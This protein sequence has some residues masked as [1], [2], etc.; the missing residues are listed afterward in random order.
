MQTDKLTIHSHKERIQKGQEAVDTARHKVMQHTWYPKYH[1]SPPA[2][3][4]NDPNGF[5]FYKGEYHLFYQHYPYL[6]KWGPM[7]WGHVKSKD[8]VF[9]ENLPIALAPGENYDLD[10][11]FSGSA[12]E[13]DGKLYLMY[14]GHVLTGPNSDDDLKQ[15]QALA[16]SEDGI[17]FE[18]ID[19]NPVIEHLPKG[20]FHPGH[21][22]DPKVWKRGDIYYVIIGAKTKDSIGQVIL[23]KSS[24]LIHWEFVSVVAKA[25]DNE[26][27]MWECPDLI[28]LGDKDILI[29]SPQGIKAEGIYY[30]NHHQSGYL[31]GDFNY[32]S[33]ILTHG[34]FRLLD[35]GFDFY[36]PQTIIDDKGRRILIAWMTMWEDEM[37]TKEFGWAGAMTLPRVLEL[38][39]ERLITK[40]IPELKQLREKEVSYNKVKIKESLGLAGILGDCIELEVEVD[41]KKASEFGIKMR[42]SKCGQ[43]K[44]VLHYDVAK[45]LL[46]LDR[47]RSGK[48][49]GGVR[50]VDIEPKKGKLYFNIFIDKSSIEVFINKGEQALTARV[51]PKETSKE[52]SFYSKGEV[53][54]VNISK[55]NLKGLTI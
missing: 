14:T 27:S 8:L 12:I 1:V 20:D 46:T 22:R 6:P 28:K 34:A 30:H 45:K 7:H 48:G 13:K 3:W 49:S 19:H 15:T 33:G 26:G 9:W 52:I 55:W 16:V 54:L 44:T 31:I 39:G 47:N 53:E 42:Q 35:F 17:I 40:P 50:S 21:F 29:I 36:A 51:F 11:C 32:D 18:K 43:E 23:Y 25:K 4:M 5:S 37:P 41:L 38:D 2:N 10:G 24:D